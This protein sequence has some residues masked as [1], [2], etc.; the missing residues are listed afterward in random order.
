MNS[1]DQH[2]RARL[3]LEERS[4]GIISD[5]DAEWLA[6]HLLGCAQCSET[7]SGLS[8]AI[9]LLRS[10]PVTAPTFL[11]SRTRTGVRIRA[12][13]LQEQAERT[14]MLAVS[15]VLAIVFSVATIY[16]GY[17]LYTA[18]GG[19][20]ATGTRA[21][22]SSF[23]LIWFWLAPALLLAVTMFGKGEWLNSLQQAGSGRRFDH[24]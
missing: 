6:A 21:I 13:E 5:T 9:A 24:E 23:A 14:R 7:E 12:R 11:V 22:V 10:E 4:L 8:A 16:G 17:L 1:M 19:W 3:L 2:E 18:W 15:F 20:A